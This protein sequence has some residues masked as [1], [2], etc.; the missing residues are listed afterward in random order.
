[1]RSRLVTGAAVAAGLLVVL[2]NPAGAATGVFNW[3]E[4]HGSDHT[5][6]NP[7]NGKCVYLDSVGASEVTNNTNVTASVYWQADCSDTPI[8]VPPGHTQLAYE[9]GAFFRYHAVKFG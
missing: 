4:Y 6:T 9:G 3:H 2:A 8:V 7:P 1:M 5:I